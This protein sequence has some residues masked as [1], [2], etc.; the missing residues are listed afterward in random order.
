M[1]DEQ[2]RYAAIDADYNVWQCEKCDHMERF[3]ADG[4]Y[5][6]DWSFCPHCGRAIRS[7]DGE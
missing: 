7:Q 3:E 6:N 5:E 4:P 1:I 2:T